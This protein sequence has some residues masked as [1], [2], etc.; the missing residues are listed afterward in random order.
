MAAGN[1]SDEVRTNPRCTT[2]E[3]SVDDEDSESD[4][5]VIM[6]M[7]ENSNDDDVLRFEAID[8]S[9]TFQPIKPAPLGVKA[10]N[11]VI[12]YCIIDQDQDR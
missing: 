9:N 10:A 5:E 6:H 12:V 4:N 7:F 2:L 8:E 1:P 11:C 3:C